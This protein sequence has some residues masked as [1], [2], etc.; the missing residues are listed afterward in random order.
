MSEWS[1]LVVANWESSREGSGGRDWYDGG[2]RRD[3][4]EFERWSQGE[5]AVLGWQG[6]RKL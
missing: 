5:G 1:I 3:G 2:E 4:R 6:E